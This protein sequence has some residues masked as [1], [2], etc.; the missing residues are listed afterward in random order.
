MT[1]EFH[2]PGRGMSNILLL[3]VVL[4]SGCATL[5]HEPAPTEAKQP[6]RGGGAAQQPPA[7]QKSAPAPAQT[8]PVQSQ[9]QAPAQPSAPVPAQQSVPADQGAT[10]PVKP[11][12][13]VEED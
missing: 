2:G 4:L 8:A 5:A 13:N 11:K 12:H 3:T 1:T 9:Q 6:P 10:P 7:P